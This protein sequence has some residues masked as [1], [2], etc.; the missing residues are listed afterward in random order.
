MLITD[1]KKAVRTLPLLAEFGSRAV[2]VTDLSYDLFG[3]HLKPL[4]DF[5]C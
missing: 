2:I 3:F 4:R 1:P 5:S